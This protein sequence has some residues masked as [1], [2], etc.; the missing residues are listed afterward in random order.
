MSINRFILWAWIFMSTRLFIALQISEKNGGYL[1]SKPP[2]FLFYRENYKYQKNI[3]SYF[4]PNLYIWFFFHFSFPPLCTITNTTNF[5]SNS[6]ICILHSNIL[7]CFTWKLYPSYVLFAAS[8]PFFFMG[9]SIAFYLGPH[10]STIIISRF[11]A[12]FSPPLL[13]YLKTRLSS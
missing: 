5:L 9:L 12:L 6:F 13:R 2:I 4:G 11:P 3:L 7:I 10:P 1:L 8:F